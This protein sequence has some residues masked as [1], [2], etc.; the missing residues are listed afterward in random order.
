MYNNVGNDH[1]E[2]LTSEEDGKGGKYIKK[3]IIH[4]KWNLGELLFN[5]LGTDIQ[6]KG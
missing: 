1:N 4:L 3:G 2:L 6:K 5:R